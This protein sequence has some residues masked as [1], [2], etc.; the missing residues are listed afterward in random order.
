MKHNSTR[1][2]A[3][4]I[5][6]SEKALDDEIKKMGVEL[7]TYHITNDD[8]DSYLFNGITIVSDERH[9]KYNLVEMIDRIN[10][11]CMFTDTPA[12]YMLKALAD[13]DFVG[14]AICDSR[15]DFSRIHGRRD[16]KRRLIGY[17][18]HIEK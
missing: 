11:E 12:T 8:L 10:D 17:L 7:Y 13:R 16:A 14:V 5:K 9:R 2:E 3:I 1:K 6:E 15:D 4:R 18:K